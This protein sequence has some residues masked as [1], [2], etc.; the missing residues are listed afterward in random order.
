MNGEPWMQGASARL[1]II[2]SPNG[3]WPDIKKFLNGDDNRRA[4]IFGET[5]ETGGLAKVS[6][7]EAS[8]TPSQIRTVLREAVSV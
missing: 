3:K 2:D 7:L 1:L 8:S 6:C 5:P 4:I